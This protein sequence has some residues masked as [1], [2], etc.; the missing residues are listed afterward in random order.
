MTN[1]DAMLETALKALLELGILSI[2]AVIMWLT[3]GK[4]LIKKQITRY[5]AEALKNGLQEAYDDP[6][7]EYGQMVANISQL[8]LVAALKSLSELIPED[9]NLPAHPMIN[10]FFR[11]AEDHI[12]KGIMGAFGRQMKK[13]QETGGAG[14]TPGGIN[15][16]ALLGGLTGGKG[17]SDQMGG[18]GNIMGLLQMVGNMQGQGG[19]NTPPKTGGSGWP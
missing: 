13:M 5:G 19:G 12:F 16:M 9:P 14:A 6:E 7:G 1:G 2:G 10:S 8:G 15:P 11:R 3:L 17:G 4:Y 18:L